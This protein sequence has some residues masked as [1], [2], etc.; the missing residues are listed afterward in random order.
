MTLTPK[1]EK[2]CQ[3]YIKCGNQSM[4]YRIAYNTDN[5]KPETINT[6][7]YEL[8][9]NGNI[10]DRISELNKQIENDNIATAKEI[11]TILTQIL[12]GNICE[13]VPLVIGKEVIN[14]TKEATPRDRI[15]SADLLSKMRGY[16]NISVN[17]QEQIKIIDDI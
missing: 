7:A 5:M 3:E 12:R 17:V 1:Q 14:A 16:Y 13:Q 4:A 9:Q 2:F 10:T 6:K 8:M 15:K 11:Q